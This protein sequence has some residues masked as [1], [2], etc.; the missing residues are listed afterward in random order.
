MT[1]IQRFCKDRVI[2]EDGWIEEQVV[3]FILRHYC[4]SFCFPVTV[5]T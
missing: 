3:L 5:Y 1:T 4:T 2:L